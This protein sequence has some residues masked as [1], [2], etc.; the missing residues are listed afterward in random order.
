MMQD[1]TLTV[2]QLNEYVRR[3]LA[4]DPV[5]RGL[6]VQGEISGF[7]RA[8]SGHLYFSLKD[9]QARVQCVMFRPNA[10]RLRFVPADGMR[11]TVFGSASLFAQTGAF[12]VYADDMER[13]GV[14]EMYLRFEALK[15]RLAAEGLFDAA[16]KRPLPLLPK[17]VGIATSRSGAVLHDILRVGWKRW[18]NMRFVLAPCS[19]Q[20]DKAAGEIVAALRALDESGLCD[21]ILCGRGGGSLEELWP[22]NEEEVARAIRASHTPIVSCVGHETDFTIADLAA[23]VRAATPTDAAQIVLPERSAFLEDLAAHREELDDAMCGRI[24]SEQER[25][26]AIVSG[27]AFASPSKAWVEPRRRELREQTVRLRAALSGRL[28]AERAS[29][30]ALPVRLDAA[31]E[32][33]ENAAITQLSEASRRLVT[34]YEKRILEQ[35]NTLRLAA[36]AFDALRPGAPLERGWALIERGGRVCGSLDGIHAGDVFSVTMRDGRVEAR[37]LTDPERSMQHAEEKREDL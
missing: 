37:A 30:G 29:F 12:Q 20:G 31:Y 22:F 10:M 2:S 27:Y 8:V 24:S 15:S 3:Q 6:R 11:V 18:P 25:L 35:K 14:G 16:L 33:R 9:E 13:T 7:K 36:G 19:V 26:R 4:A 1:W 32:R 28:H 5:L 21:V 17:C 34:A 23:D